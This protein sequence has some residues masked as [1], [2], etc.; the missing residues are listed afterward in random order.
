MP[1]GQ[2]SGIRPGSPCVST[3]R[4]ISVKVGPEMLGRV[5]DGLGRPADG[6]GGFPY[7][8]LY[9]IDRDPPDP[10]KRPRISEVLKVGVKAID[11]L[12]NVRSRSACWN[13][14]GI[15]SWKKYLNGDVSS[16]L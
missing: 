13:F 2:I 6:K 9:D 5:L 1:L 14:C 4:P 11:G 8:E 15:W 3:G 12:L 16:E 7:E 10:I